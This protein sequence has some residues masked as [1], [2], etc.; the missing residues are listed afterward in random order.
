VLIQGK[1]RRTKRNRPIMIM[2]KFPKATLLRE[3]PGSGTKKI[4]RLFRRER[5]EKSRLIGH[6]NIQPKL[7]NVWKI[8]FS[9]W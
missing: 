6:R 9:L 8:I 5:A 7:F 4:Q 2:G 1:Y 3:L